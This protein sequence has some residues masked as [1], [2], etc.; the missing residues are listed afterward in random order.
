MVMFTIFE[1]NNLTINNLTITTGYTLVAIYIL[2]NSFY[3]NFRD[4]RV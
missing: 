2:T 4:Y 3:E 1:N